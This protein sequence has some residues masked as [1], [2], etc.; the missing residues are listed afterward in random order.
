MEGGPIHSA[1]VTLEDVL[2]N[3]I[4]GPEQLCLD[5]ECG[6][7]SSA[8]TGHTVGIHHTATGHTPVHTGPTSHLLL[9]QT[10]GIPNAHGLIE[11]GRNDEILTGVEGSA[12]D[13]VIVSSEDRQT[14]TTLKVPKTES[15]I[16]RRREDPGVLGGIGVELDGAD[17]IQVTQEGEETA[18]EL[19]IPNLDLVVVTAGYDERFVQVE[20]DATDRTVVLL[21]TVNDGT[22]AVVPSVAGRKEESRSEAG[23]W[24]S[25]ENDVSL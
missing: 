18:A 19:V 15:L 12:H 24:I 16:I 7:L 9:A 13:V 25:L 1:V 4:V 3:D 5:V 22:D 6:L 17:V 14:R 23:E 21:E 20:V 2:D 8:G 10:G 11:G